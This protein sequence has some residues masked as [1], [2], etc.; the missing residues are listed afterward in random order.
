MNIIH[1]SRQPPNKHVRSKPIRVLIVDDSPLMREMIGDAL[2]AQGDFE[3]AGL[4]ADGRE[5]LE[6]LEQTQPDILTLDLL[7]PGVSG[8]ET[9]DEILKRRPTPV[10]VVSSISQRAADATLSALD[11]GAMDYVAKPAGLDDARRVFEAELPQKL[12]NMAGADVELVLR[13][14]RARQRGVKPKGGPLGSIPAAPV[15]TEYASACIAIGVSTGGPP[16]LTSLF[17]ALAPPLP[18][19][20]V[21]QHMPAMFTGPFAARLNLLSEI[22]VREAVDGDVL[23]PNL[24]LV[25]PGG[26]HMTIHR[27]PKGNVCATIRDGDPVSGHRPSVDVLMRSAAQVYGGNCLGVVMTGMGRDGSDGCAAIRAAGGFVLGQDQESSDVYGMNKVAFREGNVDR[28]AAL[29]AL[30]ELI[31]HH[32]RRLCRRPT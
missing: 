22:E 28:Q 32:V 16:A 9:L 3:I 20:L 21:V 30:P 11:R 15:G 4:A 14:R 31:T 26:K 17:E 27:D 29:E 7:M 13:Y 19:I 8:E 24:A 23:K 10:I 12:R 25:A 6:L 5:A 18:P 1:Q 2:E